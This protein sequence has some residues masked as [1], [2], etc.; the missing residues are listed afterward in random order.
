[1]VISAPD[2]TLPFELMCDAS[3]HAIGAVL[4][5]RHDKLLHVIYYA[6]F[7]IEIRDKKGTENQVADHLSRIPHDKG[8]AHDTSVNELFP[9]E[10]LMTVH[11]APWFADIANF[12]ATGDLPPEINKHQKRKL[13]NDAKYFVWDEPYLFKKCSDGIL[14]RCISEEEGREVL[15]NC[16]SSCYGAMDYVSKWVEAIA[17]PTNDNKVVMNFLRK[18]IFSRFGVPR[19]LISDGGSHFCNRPLEALLL[20][21]GMKHK[22][23]TPY[24][25]QVAAAASGAVTGHGVAVAADGGS[26]GEGFGNQ[27]TTRGCEHGQGGGWSGS[28]G[29]E[30]TENNLT[31]FMAVFEN[32]AAAMQATAVALGNQTGNMNGGNRVNGSMTLATFM[33]VNPPIFRGTTNPMEVDNWFRPWKE[34][35]KCNRSLKVNMLSLLHTS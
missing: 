11:K 33:K 35:C 14:R 23:A 8:G 24:H 22:V 15:W 29:P 31:N 18:N 34:P 19:A 17:T 32:M 16:H 6:K 12:K 7:D 30:T 20:R 5:Q 26:G 9:N 25:P 2:W 4:G 21:Y 27:M 10:Q 1:P 28:E 3:D 13:I